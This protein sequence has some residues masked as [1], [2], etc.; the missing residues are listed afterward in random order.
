MLGFAPLASGPLADDGTAGAAV[1]LTLTGV[2]AATAVGPV[3]IWNEIVPGQNAAWGEIVP[4]Q[5][6]AWG[7]IVPGQDASWN[8]ITYTQSPNWTKMAA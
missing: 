5:N 2:S 3:L 4:G 7:K 8:S 1:S 6:A